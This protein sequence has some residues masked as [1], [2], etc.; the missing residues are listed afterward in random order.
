MVSVQHVD[1]F[2]LVV[3]V[4][5]GGA[6]SIDAGC[7]ASDAMSACVLSVCSCVA[8]S[9]NVNGVC[10]KIWDCFFYVGIICGLYCSIESQ[11]L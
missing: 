7:A 10:G 1:V 2:C 11:L 9:T 5:L 8:G 4:A 6:C 3:T